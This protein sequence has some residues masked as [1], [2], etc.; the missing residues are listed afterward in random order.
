MHVARRG[1]VPGPGRS[2]ELFFMCRDKH[3]LLGKVTK[4]LGRSP[5]NV[6]D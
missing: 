6:L 2:V 4:H 3:C 1:D 5:P